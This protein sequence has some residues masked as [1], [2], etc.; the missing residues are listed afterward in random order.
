VL[1]DGE[2]IREFAAERVAGKR[3][4]GAGCTLSAAIAACLARGLSVIDAI[5]AAKRYVTRARETAPHNLGHG[6]QPLNHRVHAPI[7][8]RDN[9]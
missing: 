5:D 3:A 7:A 4:H 1:Y 8:R 2:D 6:A 9:G